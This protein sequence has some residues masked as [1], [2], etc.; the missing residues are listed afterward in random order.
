MDVVQE[1]QIFTRNRFNWQH[2]LYVFSSNTVFIVLRNQ[3]IHLTLMWQHRLL[4]E[5]MFVLG[6]DTFSTLRLQDDECSEH[7]CTQA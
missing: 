3:C 2:S 1:V 5:A 7:E 6:E 4:C